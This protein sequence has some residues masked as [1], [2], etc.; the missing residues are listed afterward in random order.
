MPGIACLVLETL[1]QSGA[2]RAESRD[3]RIVIVTRNDAKNHTEPCPHCREPVYEDAERCPHCGNYLSLEDAPP[4]R[5][6]L[7]IILGA[8]I[9]IAIV[10]KWIGIW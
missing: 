4:A 1:S 9:C 6:P 7:W 8:L 3:A 10:L 2:P 5:R